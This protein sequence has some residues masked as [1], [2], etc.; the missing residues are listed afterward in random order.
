MFALEQ[1]EREAQQAATASANLA[2]ALSRFSPSG[3]PVSS[4][5]KMDVLPPTNRPS[6]TACAHHTA[7]S[8]MVGAASGGCGAPQLL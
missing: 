7:C 4:L 3:T 1:A 8:A 5:A 6:R 2:S